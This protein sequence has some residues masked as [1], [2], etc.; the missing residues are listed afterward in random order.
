M[1]TIAITLGD[2]AGI[3]PEV[4]HKALRS[5]K[6]DSHFRYEIVMAD[7]A[8]RVTPG[9]ISL[10]AGHFA[11]K[12]LEGGVAGCLR[13]D[14]AAL[15]TAPVHKAGLKRAGFQ[16]P[17]Q[18][19][20]LA[21]RTNSRRFAMML[22]GG[23][24]RVALV[25]THVPLQKVGSLLT[26]RAIHITIELTHHWLRRFGIRRPRIL[27]ASFNPH[28][29]VNDEQGPEERKMIAPAVRDARKRL[30][31]G[32]SG[33][34]SPDHVFWMAHCGEA[35]AVVCMY[36]DQG[37]IPLKM[38]AFERGVNVTLGL[39]IIRT[40]PDHGTAYDIAGKNKADPRSMIEAINLAARLSRG[41]RS[42]FR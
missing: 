24:L 10:R 29:G 13:G 42:S 4:V 28:G 41:S 35:D 33:P 30:G 15:V 36:H 16:F 21:H 23:N 25:T 8:P 1:Q 26:R 34:Y 6:L 19:E 14:Y 9:K 38:I 17:G 31:T 5:H 32:I 37:L 20:W 2:A 11:L 7:C 3:G 39:P 40:S 18:T 27:V 22:V 12:S